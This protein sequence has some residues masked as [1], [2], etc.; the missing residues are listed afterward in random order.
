[1]QFFKKISQHLLQKSQGGFR[2]LVQSSGKIL[3]IH[4]CGALLLLLSNFLIVHFAGEQYYG[5]YVSIFIWINILA[6]VA[7]FGM[8]DRLI[9]SVP[10][11]LGTAAEN[12]IYYIL[13][14]SM[15]IMTFPFL[16]TCFFL[17]VLS[18]FKIIQEISRY[19]SSLLYF[20]V[21]F[22]AMMNLLVNFLRASNQILIGQLL[23][24][25]LRPIILI[26]LLLLAVLLTPKISIRHLFWIQTLALAICAVYIG[27]WLNVRRK[28]SNTKVIKTFDK[29]ILPNIHFLVISILNV[30]IVRL[31]IIFL[32]ESRAAVEVGYYN[33]ALRL[34]DMIH[35][36][37]SILN[38]IV[39]SL[40]AKSLSNK[41]KAEVYR[42]IHQTAALGFFGTT[43]IFLIMV[44]F[45]DD[46]LA[47]YGN[48]FTFSYLIILLVGL[49]H[50]ITA[51]SG[52]INAIF[53]VNGKQ[54]ISLYCLATQLLVVF[55]SCYILVPRYGQ[56]GA[57]YSTIIGNLAYLL[58]LGFFFYRSEKIIITPFKIF[59]IKPKVY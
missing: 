33:I 52:P 59:R 17:F 49:S 36:P 32:S 43:A 14:W 16:I 12:T 27:F 41:S 25:I 40:L 7:L 13:R 58:L 10:R 48:N 3:I 5:A 53:M 20:L 39:P 21:F 23:D 55:V 35:Y 45:G 34:S 57:A 15:K 56:Y 11:Y 1:M 29:S 50:I 42:I 47:L 37:V 19:H 26:I 8:D 4:G 24:K 18:R 9:A 2:I 22:L 28:T 31:D 54:K 51:S 30:L 38:L 6:V 46:I 44:I